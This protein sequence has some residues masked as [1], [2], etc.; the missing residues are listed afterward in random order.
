MKNSDSGR[1]P[2]SD[3]TADEWRI[4]DEFISALARINALEDKFSV[5]DLIYI[6]RLVFSE[7]DIQNLKEKL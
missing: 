2:A 1:T 5:S 7:Q 6:L 4:V 3:L